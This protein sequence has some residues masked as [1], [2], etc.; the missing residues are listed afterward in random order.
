MFVAP[1]YTARAQILIDPQAMQSWQSR[2]DASNSLDTAQVESQIA[3]LRSEK[4]AIQVGR[5]LNLF[6]DSEFTSKVVP[7]GK[8]SDDVL[9]N[10]QVTARNVIETFARNVDVRRSGIS[11]A[12]DIAFSCRDAEKAARVAN[13]ISEAYVSDQIAVRIEA[14]KQSSEWLENRIDQLRRQMNLATRKAQEFRARRDYRLAD[15]TPAASATEIARNAVRD[16]KVND[17][18]PITLEELEST[19]TT[20]RKLY[21]SYLLTYTETVQRQFLQVSNARVITLATRPLKSSHPKKGVILALSGL[22][23]LLMGVGVAAL[24][25]KLKDKSPAKAT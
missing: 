6:T 20:F 22:I 1:V 12:I 5:Q 8:T 14:S 15:S 24:L 11:Y 13:A 18:D 7:A 4:I 16:G 3:V 2:T 10:D 19:A 21:E 25:N 9:Q 23:G 17:G